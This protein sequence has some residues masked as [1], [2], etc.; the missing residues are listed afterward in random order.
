MATTHYTPIEK[1]AEGKSSLFKFVSLRSPDSISDENNG[2]LF[3]NNFNTSESI[4]LR[5][6][7]DV[8][9]FG[10]FQKLK[11]ISD[12]FSSVKS[13][14]DIK[15]INSKLFEFSDWLSRNRNAIELEGLLIEATPLKKEE[16]LIIWDNLFYFLFTKKSRFIRESLIIFLIGNNFLEKYSKKDI[17]KNNNDL[18]KLASAKIVVPRVILTQPPK[19]NSIDILREKKSELNY[20][21]INEDYKVTQLDKYQKAISE[22]LIVNE[23][24]IEA[25]SNFDSSE[26][27]KESGNTTVDQ[28]DEPLT[29]KLEDVISVIGN[30]LDEKNLKDIVSIDTLTIV[31][32]LNVEKLIDPLK[33]INKIETEIKLI[34]KS[35]FKLKKLFNKTIVAGSS[36]IQRTNESSHLSKYTD[37]CFPKIIDEEKIIVDENLKSILCISE[38]QGSSG[39]ASENFFT[40]VG[41]VSFEMLKMPPVGTSFYIGLSNQNIDNNSSSIK[42][43]IC[44]RSFY[45]IDGTIQCKAFPV[46]FG[47]IIAD[48]FVNSGDSF[49]ISRATN[50]DGDMVILWQRINNQTGHQSILATQV[51]NGT[52]ITEKL[53]LDFS[54]SFRGQSIHNV[55]MSPCNKDNESIENCSGITNLGISDYMRVEQEVCCYVPGEVSHIENIMQG[56]YK[57]RS[58]RRLRR[59]E[60]TLTI[61][62][63]TITE[64]LR[65]TTTTDRYEMEQETSQ[66]IQEDSAFQI[67]VN[68]STKFGPTQLT[69]DTGFASSTSSID[70]SLQAVSYAQEISS[71][72]LERVVN[73]VREERINKVIEEFE[74]NNLHGLDNRNNPDGHVTGIYRWVDKIYKNQVVNYGKRLTFE[75][76]IPEPAKFHLW[77]M[78][79]DDTSIGLDEPLDPRD[80]GLANHSALNEFNY[81]EWAAS[82]GI[83][84]TPPPPLYRTVSKAYHLPKSELDLNVFS[85]SYNDFQIP[86]GY[87]GSSASVYQYWIYVN[88]NNYKLEITVGNQSR[89]NPHPTTNQASF[90][91]GNIEGVI[92]ISIAGDEIYVLKLNVVATCIRKAEL[93]EKWKIDVFTKIV[94]AYKQQKAE[95]DNAIA[96]AKAQ[97]SLGIQILG[98][99]PLYN[100]T[101]E[102]QELKRGCLSW[103]EVEYGKG[104]YDEITPCPTAEDMPNMNIK[105]DLAC[106]TQ[107]AK[108][109]E[110][111]FDWEIMS[112]LFYPYF[113]GKKCSW[114]EIYKL[115]D[116]DPI[117]RGFLQAGMARVVVPV[118]PNYEEAVLYYL[119]T[120]EV[121]NGG[122]APV[123][124]DPLYEGII[125]DLEPQE[126]SLVG[127]PWETRVPT[128]LNILQKD[129]AAVTGDGLPCNC[130]N[131]EADGTGGSS[132]EGEDEPTE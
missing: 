57:E 80:N 114:K 113:W 45:G 107:S 125:G 120:K 82:Y 20:N 88:N 53:Y 2:R 104:F 79:K 108:F 130:D 39:G 74:E 54:F 11:S 51:L 46:K 112:Y 40:G 17:I 24:Y 25:L 12:N 48:V 62:S 18:R 126:P 72:A 105:E 85:K 129:S 76:M 38:N 42:Y 127:E 128:S 83:E 22:L 16:L 32:E 97:S 99:N 84:V 37:G 44:I 70:S 86:D 3:I 98:N 92:P 106:Y 89:Q 119:E 55:L 23:N 68:L 63:E 121:W 26:L 50:L 101:L 124:S 77:S 111:A 6:I 61:E 52:E 66:V 5:D 56:E 4:F 9:K 75:F 28:D 14:N 31:K 78:E 13:I 87:V 110:Q 36:I 8:N 58:T 96:E 49:K 59:E 10:D 71:R 19:K 93:L 7:E 117:F 47:S 69:V 109:F 15:N 41:S 100:R 81:S 64:K 91:L 123:I 29:I 65:D 73:R 27:R 103:L 94:D 60:N 21:P 30:P 34:N 1:K 102:Q 33:A 132:L 95:Y 90:S 35:L 43:S 131:Y 116:N 115:D 118:K 67:G 122:A